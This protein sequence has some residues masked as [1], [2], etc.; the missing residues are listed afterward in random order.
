MLL[1]QKGGVAPHPIPAAG[2][3][4]LQLLPDAAG[5]AATHAALALGGA[6]QS[7]GGDIVIAGGSVQ[8]H[9]HLRRAGIEHHPFSQSRTTL[10]QMAATQALLNLV[11]A[12]EIDLIHVHGIEAGATA[13]AFA[14]AANLPLVMSVDDVPRGGFLGRRSARR[15][16]TGRP[17][18]VPSDYAAQCLIRD[19]GLLPGS[20]RIVKPGIDLAAFD[21]A[22][23]SAERTVAV[24]AHWGL[25]DDPR[26]VILVPG[27]LAD[28]AWLNWVL[29]AAVS[30]DAPD[31][32]WILLG[33]PE[34]EETALRRIRDAGAAGR[35][36][37][38][39]E[40]ADWPAALKLS[41]LVAALPLRAPMTS[42]P[43]LEAQAMGRTVVT[44]DSGA[45]GEAIAPGKTG[46]I[47]RPRDPGSLVYAVSAAIERDQVIRGAMALAAR[48]RIETAYAQDAAQAEMI[49]VY[50]EV[51]GAR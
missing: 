36:A 50:R 9:A 31:A 11:H 33:Q 20:V 48:R 30:T 49:A 28:T 27:A 16:L 14:D 21:E 22:A 3:R 15:D 5:T 10:F 42:G 17:V 23:V 35:V 8:T 13:R 41:A 19:H 38:V 26:P 29:T 43:L 40:C 18:V 12:R 24:A 7:A 44:T 34:H 6:L 2:P 47:V 32:V 51:M 25:M 45:C 1:R 37:W 46:W 4:V 39:G